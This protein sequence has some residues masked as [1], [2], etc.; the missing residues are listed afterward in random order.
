MTAPASVKHDTREVF[1][2][3][4]ELWRR[5]NKKFFRKAL[6]LAQGNRD[7]ADTFMS[8]TALSVVEYLRRESAKVRNL[9]A[10]F[11]VS[12]RNTSYDHWRRYHSDSAK[13]AA[14]AI[15]VDGETGEDTLDG[16]IVRQ[17]IEQVTALLHR[18]PKSWSEVLKLRVFEEREYH[19][20]ALQMEISQ[21]LARKRL[22]LAR[23]ALWRELRAQEQI[24]CGSLP[25]HG[26][27]TGERRHKPIAQTSI[28]TNSEHFIAGEAHG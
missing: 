24:K 15:S 27:K 10:F 19:D 1:D 6:R 25:K 21:P 18:L 26:K 9:E 13:L 7:L 14:L 3:F 28:Q 16:L 4:A 8:R 5:N 20:I 23:R 2:R 11:Y 17:E 12:L 22:Q